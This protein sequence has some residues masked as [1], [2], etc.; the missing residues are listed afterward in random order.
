VKILVVNSEYGA[1]FFDASTLEKEDAA[2]K[3][4]LKERLDE[5]WYKPY[6]DEEP[7]VE[8]LSED[9]VK[10]ADVLRLIQEK[11]KRAKQRLTDYRNS[12]SDFNDVNACLA[13]PM[14]TLR[15]GTQ[16]LSYNLL[17]NLGSSEYDDRVTLETL[18]SV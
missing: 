16:T 15:R 17:T 8:L 6:Y 2:C 1:R 7:K 11:N 18:E 12:L 4:I 14:K 5:G 13:S 3:K 10:D 9:D